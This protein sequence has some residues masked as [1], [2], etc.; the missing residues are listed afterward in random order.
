[1]V[2]GFCW[3]TPCGQIEMWVEWW[4]VFAGLN[5]VGRLKGGFLS[6][7]AV[8]QPCL[9]LSSHV[10]RNWDVRRRSSAVPHS[11]LVVDSSCGH[12]WC[13]CCRQMGQSWRMWWTVCSASLQFQSAESTMSVHFRRARKPQCPVHNL[14]I[15]VCS[16]L[17]RR[18][19]GSVEGL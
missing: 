19:T 14:N 15:V 6:S 4:Q 11:L 10:A 5:L 9:T 7:S 12:N 18:L 1:M 3:P 17:A 16:Y 8:D 2:A 13:L